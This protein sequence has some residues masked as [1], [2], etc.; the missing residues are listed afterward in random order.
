M[1]DVSVSLVEFQV[2][3]RIVKFS[4]TLVVGYGSVAWDV[5]GWCL[6]SI[7]VSTVV[8]VIFALGWLV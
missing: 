1:D 7:L 6:F 3:K 4:F 8:R 5:S 2:K